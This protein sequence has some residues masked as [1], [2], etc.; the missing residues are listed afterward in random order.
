MFYAM[1]IKIHMDIIPLMEK[2]LIQTKD[3][4]VDYNPCWAEITK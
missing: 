4:Q 3:G 1:V 2:D